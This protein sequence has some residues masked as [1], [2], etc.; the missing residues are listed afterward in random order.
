MKKEFLF[1][2]VMAVSLCEVYKHRSSDMDFQEGIT[3][4]P[5]K[6]VFP[7]LVFMPD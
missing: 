3:I 7:D 6:K 5:R 4:I 2:L 1:T